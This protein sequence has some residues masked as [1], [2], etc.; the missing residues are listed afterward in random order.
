M[1]IEDSVADGIRR[2][3]G[4]SPT[5]DLD[6]LLGVDFVRIRAT[7][8]GPE[9][10]W[11]PP[12][13]RM[14]FFGSSDKTY[15]D[16]GVVE[17]P[18]R[19]AAT[20]REVEAFSWPTAA[21]HDYSQ[22]PGRLVAA[23]DRAVITGGWTPT[24]SQLCEL[25]GMETALY[26]LA[27]APELIE[28]GA[29][30]ITELVVGLLRGVHAVA[31]GGLLI[32][33]TADDL[34]TQRGLMF[35]PETWRAYFKPRLAR[36]FSTA[37]ELG[38]VTW[39]HACGDVSAILPDLIE[40]GL[41]VLEPTQAH[42]A[43]MQAE[44]LKKEFGKDLTFFGAISTQRTLPFGTPDEVRAEV[45]ERIRVLGAGGGGYIAAPDHTVLDGV[46]PQNVIA[47]YDQVGSLRR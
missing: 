35:S 7:Y 24:F 40:I 19:Q 45:R 14:N 39:L 38:L 12:S 26:N 21:D 27:A 15:A 13:N 31:H 5:A 20:V 46:P 41:D 36:Q 6:E 42:L 2:L 32:F 10:P 23:D 9:L 28:A 44:R 1:G 30:R 18:L 16:E 17:R 43:G 37:R 33:A 11:K 47:L 34:A 8:V 3:L 25:F 4:A 29:E 22:I